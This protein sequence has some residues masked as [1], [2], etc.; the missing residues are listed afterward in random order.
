M[1]KSFLSRF[2]IAVLSL[3]LVGCAGMERDCASCTA[4]SFGGDWV[5]VQM[6]YTGKPFRCWELHNVSVSNEQHS[7]GIYWASQFGHL[8]HLSNMYNRV[9]VSGG[10]WANAYAEVGLTQATC[11]A[12]RTRTFD[13][14]KNEYVY[15]TNQGK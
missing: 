12:I 1:N 5:V 9:Q 13:P 6:D 2:R 3:L 14:V 11:T 4:T 15:P 10:D 8:V 7:D